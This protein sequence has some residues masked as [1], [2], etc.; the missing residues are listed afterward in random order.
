VGWKV[1]GRDVKEVIKS[2]GVGN[3]ENVGRIFRGGVYFISEKDELKILWLR[4][5]CAL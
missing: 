1:L 4:L 3:D 5:C 2:G